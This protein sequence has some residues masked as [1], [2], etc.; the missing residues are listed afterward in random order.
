MAPSARAKPKV[1][2]SGA[3]A[4]AAPGQCA[5]VARQ[6]VFDRSRRV[7]GYELLD[8]YP[9][10]ATE[11]TP[12]DAGT[13]RVLTASSD[14]CGLQRM[15]RGLPALVN[16]T[17]GMLI[18][19]SY[20]LLPPEHVVVELLEDVVIDDEVLVAC[21]KVK[22]AGYRLAIDDVES[23]EP[24]AKLLSMVDVVKIDWLLTTPAQRDLLCR[25]V[26]KLPGA[27]LLA[28]KVETPAEVF[29][30][31]RLG[32]RLFQGYFFQKP[33]LVSGGEPSP[34]A[35]GWARFIQEVNRP[36][37]DFGKLE[38]VVRGDAVLAAKLIRRINAASNGL[39][40]KVRSIKQALVLLGEEALRRWCAVAALGEL[41]A[42]KPSELCGSA[43]AR[44]FYCEHLG[45]DAG[46]GE[47][48]LELFSLGLMSLLDA[49]LDQPLDEVVLELRPPAAVRAA[50]LG[51]DGS[52]RK[53]LDSAVACE[54]GLDAEGLK[55]MADGL[56]VTP[57]RMLARY[58]QAIAWSDDAMSFS[59]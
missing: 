32:C 29:E 3:K 4:G 10:P 54:R 15:T 37:I 49:V 16:F 30:A 7:W 25:T 40:Q 5:H 26:A 17:R 31:E 9:R 59:G 2:G 44:A 13:A 50:L 53:V 23:L 43:L 24:Y 52:Y 51:R 47:A 14:L 18:N 57:E 38:A 56:G 34:A 21:K 48:R 12:G 19:E 42:G 58:A 35:F 45:V 11:L 22:D 36:E 27:L 55:G 46:M 1:G 8:R 20:R 33:E 41:S 6:P 39:T 28:E